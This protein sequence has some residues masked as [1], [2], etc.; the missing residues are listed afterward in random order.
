MEDG[1]MKSTI[2]LDYDVA[3]KITLATL[4][5]YRKNLK[6]ELARWKKNPKTDLNPTGYW[7]HPE[8]VVGNMRRVDLLTEVI[9]DF[10]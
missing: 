7:L 9:R 10:E 6:K 4:K 8:D 1:N 2:E 5:D 3:S